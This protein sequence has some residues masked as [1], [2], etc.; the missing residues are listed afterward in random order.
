MS[1]PEENPEAK[2]GL[3]KFKNQEVP[4]VNEVVTEDEIF[5]EYVA[6]LELRN[7]SDDE[8]SSEE[9]NDEEREEEQEPEPQPVQPP[10]LNKKRKT[11]NKITD[12]FSVQKKSKDTVEVGSPQIEELEYMS[13]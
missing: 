12:F 1:Q 8:S 6:K 10:R 7:E 13:E 9:E 5:A 4:L 2:S 3:S 11:G